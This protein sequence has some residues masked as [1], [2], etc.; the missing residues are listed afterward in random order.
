ML[1]VE[2]NQCKMIKLLVYRAWIS[3]G[4][5]LKEKKNYNFSESASFFA[6]RL[7][8]LCFTNKFNV[9]ISLITHK[10]LLQKDVFD[11]TRS[12]S[13]KL[14][15]AFCWRCTRDHSRKS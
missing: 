2:L 10:T 14:I 7:L 11:L 15:R 13:W 4:L 1:L 8:L 12:L 3:V 9:Q 6:D 5:G